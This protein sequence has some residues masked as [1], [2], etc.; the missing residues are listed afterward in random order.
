[1]PYPVVFYFLSSTSIMYT[2]S[3]FVFLAVDRHAK[4]RH[5]LA[6]A[7]GMVCTGGAVEAAACWLQGW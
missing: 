5:R 1:M 3:A 7:V 2:A 6:F 4:P